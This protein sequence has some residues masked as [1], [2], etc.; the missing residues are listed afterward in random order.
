MNVV[1]RVDASEKIGSG[2]FYR[3][4]L[5]A[6]YIKK[7]KKIHFIS[8]NLK[9]EYLIK[10]KSEKF[11]H[12]NIK[13][14]KNSSIEDANRTNQILRKISNPVDLLI[15][16]NYKLGIE[17][18][19]KTKL[20]VKKLMVIDDFFRKHNCDIYLNYTN[21]KVHKKFLPSKCLKLTGP[22]YTILNPNYLQK[23]QKEDNKKIFSIFVFMGGTDRANFTLKLFNYFKNPVFKNFKFNFVLGINNKRKN[24]LIKMGKKINNFN[25]YYNLKNLKNLLSSSSFCISNGGQV[26]W[27]IIYNK[28]PNI[29]FC[30][31]KYRNNII[32]KNKK[33]LHSHIFEINKSSL[34]QKY[35]KRINFLIRNYSFLKKEILIKKKLVDGRGLQRILQKIK[36]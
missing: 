36:I 4:F 34:F 22:K 8:N 20:Y 24:S 12:H 18:E 31:N 30:K 19:N 14:K 33:I 21:Y 35:F 10:L 25:I 5:L 15:V 13:L 11:S 3:T 23:N 2:H 9:K 17:W 32:L 29:I 7:N 6:K 28:I 16:D 1:I 27:E 26:I